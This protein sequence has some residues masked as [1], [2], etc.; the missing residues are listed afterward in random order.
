MK[1]GFVIIMGVSSSG[2]TTVGKALAAR[3]GWDFYDG[4]DYHPSAKIEKIAAGV[5]LNDED[6]LPWLATLQAMITFGLK[7]KRPGVLACSALKE[8][9]RQVLLKDNQGVVIVY[10]KG[11]F[12]LIHT[13]M[14]DR[15]DHYMKPRMLKSQ[16]DIL[17]EPV[18]VLTMEISLSVETIVEKILVTMKD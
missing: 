2:K 18:D 8:S 5:A 3:L 13:R 6:R 10:L 17:E 12:E 16:F 11:D 14:A 9:Y 15:A 7:H 4:D 1:P